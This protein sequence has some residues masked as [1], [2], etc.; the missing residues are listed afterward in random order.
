MTGHYRWRAGA[1]LVAVVA[2]ASPAHAQAAARTSSNDFADSHFHL[3]NYI[4]EGTDVRDFL[5]IMGTRVVRSTLFGIP[6]QQTWSHENSGDFAPT[7]YLQSYAPLYYYSFTDAFIAMAYQSLSVEQQRRLDPMITV[8]NPAD[9]YAVDYIRRGLQVCQCV[10]S[11]IGEFSIH[12]EFVS[13]KVAGDTASLADPALDRILEFAAETG[14][15]VIFHCD[16]DMPFAKPDQEPVY[17]R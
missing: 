3:T 8:F 10:F 7:Y 13:A 4:Q 9:M 17:V 12:K 16:I 15:V 14:L 5:R 1:L 6:L 11:G 2:A